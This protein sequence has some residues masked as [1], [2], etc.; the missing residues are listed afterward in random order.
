MR[1]HALTKKESG[2]PLPLFR[3][4]GREGGI[5]THGSLTTT[6]VF[7]TAALNHS[8]TSPRQSPLYHN[9]VC[10]YNALLLSNSRRS[11]HVRH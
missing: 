6:A 10:R 7:K 9:S 11:A 3:M 5:R 4:Y 2:Y 8:T 1:G